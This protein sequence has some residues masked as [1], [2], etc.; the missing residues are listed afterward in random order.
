MKILFIFGFLSRC[1]TSVEAQAVSA[2][3]PYE[4]MHHPGIE[5]FVSY[6]ATAKQALSDL[7]KYIHSHSMELPL[8]RERGTPKPRICVGIQTTNRPRSPFSYVVQ[9][10]TSLLVRM[11][12]RQNKNDVHIHVFNMEKNPQE[13]K[14]IHLIEGLVPITHVHKE[15]PGLHLRSS[16]A[17]K[18]QEGL[19]HSVI[20]HHFINEGCQYPIL[21]E[22]D[23]IAAE[24]WVDS[25]NQAIKELPT[26]WFIIKLFSSRWAP[27]VAP[28]RKGISNYNQ[29]FSAVAYMINPNYM[30]SFGDEMID[31]I[32][33]AHGKKPGIAPKDVF[34]NDFAFQKH[35][36]IKSF[37]PSIFQHTGIFTSV[38]NAPAVRFF[39]DWYAQ[40]PAFESEGRPIVFDP[41]Q[42]DL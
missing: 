23:A 37:E 35:L 39:T 1:G 10:L 6:D 16:E 32:R 38:G 33:R 14:D 22:D 26:D 13:H 25:V 9:A 20:L 19:D 28:K 27:W 17:R 34:M 4:V 15:L 41:R 29:R 21:I 42:W 11:N 12:Y 24:N 40:T 8:F 36:E 5:K 18:G 7:K 30:A 31:M 3:P 2:E